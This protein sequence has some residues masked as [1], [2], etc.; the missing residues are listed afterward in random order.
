LLGAGKQ[1]E[2]AVALARSVPLL[3]VMKKDVLD[4]DQRRQGTGDGATLHRP[5]IMLII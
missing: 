4:A 5:Q 3:F 2:G 1:I